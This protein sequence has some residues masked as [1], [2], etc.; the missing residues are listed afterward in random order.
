M[1]ICPICEASYDDAVDFCFKDGAPLEDAPE[2]AQAADAEL[3]AAAALDPAT[4]VDTVRDRPA[5]GSEAEGDAAD[6]PDVSGFDLPDAGGLDVPEASGFDLPDATALDLPEATALD[7]PE[8][9]ALDLPEATGLALPEATALDSAEDLP[10]AEPEPPAVEA[11]ALL[12]E[13]AE[14]VDTVPSEVT[15]QE[16]P[17]EIPAAELPEEIVQ[18][19]PEEPAAEPEEL[20]PQ[21]PEEA[22]HHA[23]RREP[24]EASP[25]ASGRLQIAAVLVVVALLV[26]FAWQ[27]AG[28]RGDAPA[29]VDGTGDGAADA[30]GTTPE[31]GEAE[32]EESP[33]AIG[34]DDSSGDDDSAAGDALVGAGDDDSADMP[35]AVADAGEEPEAP[36]EEEAAPA[37]Q[38]EATPAPVAQPAASKK[39]DLAEMQKRQEERKRK[40]AAQQKRARDRERKLARKAAAE[41]AEKQRAAKAAP[42]APQGSPWATST[43]ASGA[44][45]APTAAPASGD[46]SNPWGVSAATTSSLKVSS[47]PVG[48]RVSVAGKSRGKTP[49]TLELPFGDYE[50]RVEYPGFATQ[51]RVVKLIGAKPISLDVVLESLDQVLRGTLNV[52]TA[53]PAVLYVDGARKGRTPI[54]VSISQGKHQFR[55]EVAGKPPYE[56]SLDV[57]LKAEGDKV[58]HFFALPP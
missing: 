51:S 41:K 49:L 48:A 56:E 9:T 22:E 58:T 54:S 29:I 50:V 7:L 1:K 11:M 31:P 44:G 5:G 55:L 47:K 45:A 10:A 8:A 15:A 27:L 6:L 17:E 16:P 46:A 35:G 13:S 18:A 28:L 33:A 30:A 12:E 34:D 25:P 43:P 3:P 32:G 19:E 14:E 24:S 4:E 36:G 53:V 39:S 26:I 37:P 21:E 20:A 38:P 42:A 23:P 40:E 2:A 52:V 57:K